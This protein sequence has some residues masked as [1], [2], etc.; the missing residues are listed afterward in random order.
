MKKIILL[1]VFFGCFAMQSQNRSLLISSFKEV[2]KL[3]KDNPKPMVVFIHTDWCKFCQAMDKTTFANAKVIKIIN[4]SFYFIKLNAEEK[5]DIT[6]LGKTFKYKPSGN[7]TGIHELA[8]ALA[9]KKGRISYPTTVILNAEFEIDA[10][11]DSYIKNKRF[12]KI[13]EKYLNN[14]I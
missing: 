1:V 13:L 8:T 11:L 5:E 12:V 4:E 9:L 3:Q 14:K 2:E 7:N 6:F 10:Q